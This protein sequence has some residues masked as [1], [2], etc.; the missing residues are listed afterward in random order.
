MTASSLWLAIA[1]IAAVSLTFKATGPALLG[2][3]QFPPH[4][5]RVI[6][7]L[8]PV[9]LTAL[10]VVEVVGQH[11]SELSWPILA[12]LATAASTRLLKAPPLLAVALGVAA[13]ALLRLFT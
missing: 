4:L 11:W 12:G 1:A 13:T 5:Q 2:Q 8:A 9:L 6:A 10:V 7:L 3:R